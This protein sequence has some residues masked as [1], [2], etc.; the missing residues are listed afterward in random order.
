MS[1]RWPAAARRN[2]ATQA[3][4]IAMYSRYVEGVVVRPLKN[5]DSDRHVLGAYLDGGR[6]PVGV[7]Q[8]T[9]VGNAAEI[10]VEVADGGPDRVRRVLV[11]ELAAVAR[12]AGLTVVV[13][14]GERHRRA[15]PAMTSAMSSVV[16]RQAVRDTARPRAVPA[17]AAP[18]GAPPG[19]RPWPAAATA[20][21]E[22]RRE[23]AADAS[24]LL[25]VGVEDSKKLES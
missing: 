2:I 1:R 15:R 17:R 13:D 25:S 12:A 11:G 23:R 24:R 7:G 18:A 3:T 6:E 21:A 20:G 22:P 14:D 8:L 5:R 4:M 19:A 9:R 10:A 16:M